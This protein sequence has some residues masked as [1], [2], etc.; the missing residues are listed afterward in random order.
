MLRLALVLS[1]LFS[2]PERAVGLKPDTATVADVQGKVTAC[3]DESSGKDG[4]CLIFTAIIGEATLFIVDWQLVSFKV[5]NGVSMQTIW[6][7]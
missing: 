4:H 5:W 6:E 2:S 3:T 7:R 1:F